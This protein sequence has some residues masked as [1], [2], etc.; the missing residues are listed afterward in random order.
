M[1]AKQVIDLAKRFWVVIAG[2]LWGAA[3]GKIASDHLEEIRRGHVLAEERQR[4]DDIRSGRGG[5]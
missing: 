3:A 1:S 2:A 4:D 5:R